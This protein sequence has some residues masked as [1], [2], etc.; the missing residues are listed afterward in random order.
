MQFSKNED[1]RRRK[2]KE[3]ARKNGRKEGRGA[4]KLNGRK[5]LKKEI[6]VDKTNRKV[7]EEAQMEP[8]SSHA[9]EI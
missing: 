9:K 8:T 6:S 1:N 3:L 4:R 2:K 5:K 7:Q